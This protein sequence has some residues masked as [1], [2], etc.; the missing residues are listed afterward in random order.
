M[1]PPLIWVKS[2]D[3][4]TTPS[5]DVVV[6]DIEED[7]EIDIEKDN[8]SISLDILV[9]SNV[10]TVIKKWNELGLRTSNRQKYSYL[11]SERGYSKL[12]KVLEDDVVWE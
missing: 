2:S 6:S 8:N 1:A 11:L 10:D 4:K 5:S 9:S 12:L 3:N 7:K